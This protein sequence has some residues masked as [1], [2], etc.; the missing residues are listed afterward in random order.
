MAPEVLSGQ[1]YVGTLL[2]EMIG[3]LVE[4]EEMIH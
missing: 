3:G 2:Y 4:N 1:P